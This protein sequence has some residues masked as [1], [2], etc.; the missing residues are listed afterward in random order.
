MKE[1]KR[2]EGNENSSDVCHLSLAATH[3]FF[4]S[5]LT[6]T[7]SWMLGRLQVEW[8]SMSLGFV[9]LPHPAQQTWRWK[10]QVILQWRV[11]PLLGHCCFGG[12][13]ALMFRLDAICSALWVCFP[14]CFPPPEFILDPSEIGHNQKCPCW[15]GFILVESAIE[16]DLLYV[17]C[18]NKRFPVTLEYVFTAESRTV[19]VSH[20]VSQSGGLFLAKRSCSCHF[21]RLRVL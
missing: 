4:P 18:T 10:I 21:R 17:A 2:E 15:I 13:I 8:D 14:Q 6:D 20:L 19:N 16:F 9:W 11:V 12:G 7:C 1:R 5:Y 3:L